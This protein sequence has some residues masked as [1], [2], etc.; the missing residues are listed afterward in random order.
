[1]RQLVKVIM[2][3]ML[4]LLLLTG[5]ESIGEVSNGIIETDQLK[6]EFLDVGQAD[7]ILLTTAEATMLVDAGDNK[8]EKQIVT[9]LQ[10]RGI[11]KIDYLIGTHP[12]ADHIGGLD[13]VI[14][15]FEIGTIYMPK[16]S[17]TTKTFESVLKSVKNKGYQITTGKAGVSFELGKNIQVSMLSPMEESYKEMNDYSI[18]LKVVN[19]KDS[20]LLTGDAEELVEEQLLATNAP[21]DADIIKLGHHGSSSSSTPE[22]IEKV[23]PEVAIIT[24]GK[25]NS[26][27]HPHK[28]TLDT[29][30]K[31]G[32]PY[33][34]TQDYGTI[35]I[36]STGAG[37]HI[38]TSK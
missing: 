26:Y 34:D 21:V 20:I 2:G 31:F 1:M 18:V 29:L 5:C 13:K 32:I 27:G 10:D 6:I 7:A 25:D 33:Y 36:I 14:D 38:E 17:H 23:S 11:K 3:L 15:N 19:G 28:E 4:T 24:S 22:F 30:N 16:V 35:T 9:M 37:W 8:T 12:H